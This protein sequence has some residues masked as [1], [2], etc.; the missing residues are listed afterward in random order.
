MID[1]KLVPKVA[2][3]EM[4]RVHAEEVE[5]LNTLEKYLD[6]KD[7]EGIEKTLDEMLEHTR[8]HF[9]NEERLMREVNFPPYMMHKS[10]HDRVLN[11]FQFVVMDWRN[12]KDDAMLRNYFLETIPEWL[13]QHIASMDTMTAQFICMHKGC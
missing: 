3:D 9:A 6:A 4:N 5:L 7:R 11:E 2:F 12:H 8:G 10:E 1:F 13:T